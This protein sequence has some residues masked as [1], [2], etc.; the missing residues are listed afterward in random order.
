M[1]KSSLSD[2]LSNERES[3]SST[4][5]V[6]VNVNIY[7]RT[8]HYGQF[9]DVRALPVD[10]SSFIFCWFAGKPVYRNIISGFLYEPN[11]V[12]LATTATTYVQG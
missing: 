1:V 3:L 12:Q 7:A 11:I 4:Q 10:V 6:N 2:E 5:N 8:L 9:S